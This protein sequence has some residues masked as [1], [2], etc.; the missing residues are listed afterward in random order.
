MDFKDPQ[1]QKSIIVGILLLIVG[2]VYF[3]TTFM[4]FFFNPQKAKISSLASEYEKMSAEL[5]KARQTVGNLAKLES[6][7]DRL[8]EKWVAAQSLLPQQEEVAK[9]LRK[10][11]RAGNQAGIEFH[12]FQP[13]PQIRKEFVTENPVK[14]RVQGQYHDVGIFLSKVANLDRILNVHG[15]KIYPMDS[16]K[17]ST[18]KVGRSHTIEAEMYISAYTLTEGGEVINEDAKKKS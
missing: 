1:V 2:Y 18:D 17:A 15:L 10:V 4:P 11:T 12:L 7:Y 14:I 5:E 9:L 8:H 3:F 6:E 16:K 13:Q